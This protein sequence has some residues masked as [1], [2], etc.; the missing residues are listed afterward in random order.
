[1]QTNNKP[2]SREKLQST[3]NLP[4]SIM[5]IMSHCK[6]SHYRNIFTYIA[7]FIAPRHASHGTGGETGSA[8]ASSCI[9]PILIRRVLMGMENCSYECWLGI[10]VERVTCIGILCWLFLY[11]HLV[12]LLESLEDSK[13]LGN[14]VL[15]LNLKLMIIFFSRH[16]K[17]KPLVIILKTPWQ[18][19]GSHLFITLS[20]L[21]N[22]WLNEINVLKSCLINTASKKKN[23]LQDLIF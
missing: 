2:S 13:F 8:V 3:I 4:C 21:L 20:R 10:S 22:S 23:F 9:K 18:V 15:I 7:E 6:F 14:S 12:W 1:M 17:N 11:T 19:N 5:V 16:F